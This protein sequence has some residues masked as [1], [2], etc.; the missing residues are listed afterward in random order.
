MCIIGSMKS[1]YIFHNCFGDRDIFV[2]LFRAVTNCK[3]L[4]DISKNESYEIFSSLFKSLKF[5]D[6][7]VISI[8]AKLFLYWLHSEI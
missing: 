8:Y 4:M 3:M 1:P 5:Q 2:Y 7:A 6:S